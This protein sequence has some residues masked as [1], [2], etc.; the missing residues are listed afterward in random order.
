MSISRE[1]HEVSNE[2]QL[3]VLMLVLSQPLL[4]EVVTD[5]RV[6]LDLRDLLRILLFSG[7]DGFQQVLE[8]AID[9]LQVG[10]GERS[11]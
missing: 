3:A 2:L 6:L 8:V 4:L 9:G 7:H 5:R 10:T 1:F 11:H